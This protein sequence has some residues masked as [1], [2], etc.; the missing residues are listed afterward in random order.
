VIACPVEGS[1]RDTKLKPIRGKRDL[2]PIDTKR[3]S[4]R[5]GSPADLRS[6]CSPILPFYRQIETSLNDHGTGFNRIRMYCTRS[7]L[8]RICPR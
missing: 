4:G 2:E 7:Y 3:N 8:W 1:I 5:N 6:I